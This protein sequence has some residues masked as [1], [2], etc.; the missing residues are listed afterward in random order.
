MRIGLSTGYLEGFWG[1]WPWVPMMGGSERL[2][3]ELACALAELGHQVT[4]RLPYQMPSRVWRD[5]LW[6]GL[7]SASARFD[8]LFLF[9]DFKQRDRGDREALVAC[10]SDPPVHTDYDQIIFLSKH[11][12]VHCGHPQRPFVGGGVSLSDYAEPKARL[13]RR[14]ICTSS[15]DRCHRAQAIGKFFDFVHSYKPVNDYPSIQLD[16]P[17]LIDLQQTAQVLIY[18]LSPTRPSDFFSM[19][20]L[21]SLAAGTPVIVSDADSMPELWA[22]AAIVLPTPIDLSEWV[23]RV[24]ELL[25]R[26]ALW[27]RQSERGLKKAQDFAWPLVAQRYLATALA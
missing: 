20:V 25:E 5:V 14:V 8:L 26:P 2:A 24:E 21:E 11:H 12:A 17:G 13:V 10:R 23:V 1:T 3:T 15:P 7:D 18:P 6:C 22:D 27:Q 4:V 16:R 9:D 19:A